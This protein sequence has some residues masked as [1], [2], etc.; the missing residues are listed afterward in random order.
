L[1]GELVD[2]HNEMIALRLRHIEA[3]SDKKILESKNRS[4]IKRMENKQKEVGAREYPAPAIIP[5]ANN[6][7]SRGSVCSSRRK[8]GKIKKTWK[9]R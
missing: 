8:L 5:P 3:L 6:P 9:W 1:V 4:I 2:K 7:Q